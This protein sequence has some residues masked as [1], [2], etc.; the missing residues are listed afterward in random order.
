MRRRR[1]SKPPRAFRFP[2][3]ATSPDTTAAATLRPTR[4]AC[5]FRRVDATDRERPGCDAGPL[6]VMERV[7]PS[8]TVGA[9]RRLRLSGNGLGG[10]DLAFVARGLLLAPHAAPEAA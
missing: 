2:A 1:S 9:R 8:L 7:W 6:V 3:S 5:R 10:D 4:D